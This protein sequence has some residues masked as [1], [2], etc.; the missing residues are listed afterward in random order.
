M[1]ILVTGSSGMIGT[2]LC[3]KLLEKNFKVIGI[4]KNKNIFNKN[5]DKITKI[6]DLTKKNELLKVFPKILT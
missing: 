6:I 4:D 2:R 5:V 3:E 1:N